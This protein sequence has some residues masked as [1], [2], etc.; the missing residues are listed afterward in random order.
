VSVTPVVLISACGLVL[1]ALYNRLGVILARLRAFHQQKI[2]LLKELDRR[3]GGEQQHLLVDLIDSQ[4]AKV[5][6]KARVIQY[7]LYCLL[8][9]V[10]ALLLC[11]LLAAA[12]VWHESVGV[13]ALGMHVLGVALFLAGVGWALRELTLSLT[14]LEEESAYLE[15]LTTRHQAESQSRQK[16]RVA[17]TA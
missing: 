15:V 11:S 5:T 1:L 14:P 2:E 12:A 8:A 10:L 17:K 3:E 13:A 7:G 9:A 16:I 4:L 6:A